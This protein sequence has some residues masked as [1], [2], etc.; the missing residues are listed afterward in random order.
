MERVGVINEDG[1]NSWK[2]MSARVES[3]WNELQQEDEDFGDDVP[4]EF[5]DPVMGTLMTDPARDYHKILK[6]KLL[7]FYRFQLFLMNQVFVIS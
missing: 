1:A 2:Q 7:I 6:S 5:L 3:R 4:D